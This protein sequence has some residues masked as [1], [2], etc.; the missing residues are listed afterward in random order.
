MEAS[1]RCGARGQGHRDPIASGGVF[2]LCCADIDF[3]C[4]I[5]VQDVRQRSDRSILCTRGRNL[6][7]VDRRDR[8]VEI[9]DSAV[10]FRVRRRQRYRRFLHGCRGGSRLL[11]RTLVLIVVLVVLILGLVDC[12]PDGLAHIVRSYS[13]IRVRCGADCGIPAIPLVGEVACCAGGGQHIAHRRRGLSD[14]VSALLDGDRRTIVQCRVDA[15]LHLMAEDG[16]SQGLV[17]DPDIG[18][19]PIG[20][21]AIHRK[22]GL[23]QRTGDVVLIICR[24]RSV[25][26]QTADG[27]VRQ[28]VAVDGRGLGRG[29]G[30]RIIEADDSGRVA[31]AECSNAVAVFDNIWITQPSGHA[32]ITVRVHFTGVVAVFHIAVTRAHDTANALVTVTRSL[33]GHAAG[34][35]ALDHIMFTRRTTADD[36]ADL[37]I[38]FDARVIGAAIDAD[39]PA[40]DTADATY[41]CFHAAIDGA[42]F[43]AVQSVSVIIVVARAADAADAPCFGVWI[44]TLHGSFKVAVADGRVVNVTGNAAHD[45]VS[46]HTS[47]DGQ[48][49]DDRLRS[50]GVSASDQ[51]KQTDGMVVALCSVWLLGLVDLQAGNRVSVSVKHAQEG[52]IRHP[53][54]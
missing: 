20:E 3:R 12:D 52:L 21:V 50:V 47:L 23:C 28:I 30:V 7:S 25:R 38:P 54:I 14:L 42:V 44:G 17:H 13:V 4:S 51:T 41:V 11:R 32:A 18:N 19:V 48:V 36:A 34:V 26:Q 35:V 16:T 33:P 22:L 45:A 37:I 5:S 10:G 46:R 39:L 9:I 49:F 15:A 2:G 43:N 8:L 29:V 31:A 53:V 1:R 27:R 24:S 40:A 6:V